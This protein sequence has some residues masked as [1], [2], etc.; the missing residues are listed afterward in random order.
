MAD[1][2]PLFYYLPNPYFRLRLTPNNTQLI[3]FWDV[4][5]SLGGN[6]GDGERLV[7]ALNEAVGTSRS[8]L[9]NSGRS[10]LLLALRVLGVKK[11]DEVILPAVSCHSVADSIIASGATPVLAE[12]KA[13]DGTIDPD[14]LSGC[15][16]EKTKAIIQIYYLGLP[17]DISEVS[18]VASRRNI[19]VIGDC[20]QALGSKYDRKPLATQTPLSFYS[21]GPDKHLCFGN[22]GMLAAN[23]DELADRMYQLSPKAGDGSGRSVYELLGR[24]LTHRRPLYGLGTIVKTPAFGFNYLRRK[25]SISFSLEAMPRVA[26]SYGLRGVKQLE[27]S[28][29]RRVEN[30]TAIGEAVQRSRSLSGVPVDSVKEPALLKYTVLAP[31][32][33]VRFR[34]MKELKRRGIEAGPLNWRHPLHRWG[35]YGD[36]CQ[37][38]T[39]LDAADAFADRFLNLP[40]HP[41]MNAG[42]LDKIA[43]SLAQF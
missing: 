3:S 21:F 6:G 9:T 4:F 18:E 13:A 43:E 30:S 11:G 31:D 27:R 38:R 40:C 25:E 20:A 36:L 14:R 7:G 8:V 29:R 32:R 12:V 33:S 26:A 34:L 15:I 39:T 1:S 23:S 2:D 42:E 37:R 5:R 22:G 35:R 19:P 24:S 16:S 41:R 17:C 10:A 28:N